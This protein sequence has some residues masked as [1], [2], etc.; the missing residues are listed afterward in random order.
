LHRLDEAGDKKRVVLPA[1][2]KRKKNMLKGEIEDELSC[3]CCCCCQGMLE[4][5]AGGETRE[6]IERTEKVVRLKYKH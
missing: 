4:K 6:K 2:R 3:C 5:S 1:G